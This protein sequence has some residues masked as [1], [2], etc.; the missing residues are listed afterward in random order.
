MKTAAIIYHSRQG[1]TQFIAQQIQTGI[2]SHQDIEVDS[3]NA[4]DIIN[5]PEILIRYDGLIWGSPT[6]LGGVSSKLKQLMDATGPLWKQQSFKG[7][8]AA[9]FTVSSLPAGDKQ[10]TLISI[11]TFCMQHG[12]LWVGNP[13]LPEQHQG[14]AYAKA[15]NRL[16]SWSGLM[17]QA[18]HGSNADGFDEGDI[19][20]AQQFGENF[21]LTLNAYQGI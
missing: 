12:M 4:E 11:F 15:A 8:L 9:G 16:G 6:Y 14:V 7:K 5:S 18:E 17:A 1:H 13:I 3:L 2:L 10:S 19:K 21:A 20:T